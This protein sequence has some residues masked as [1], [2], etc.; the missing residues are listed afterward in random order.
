[1]ALGRYARPS[2]KLCARRRCRIY[3]D[4]LASDPGGGLLE[5]EAHAPY[6]TPA[7][8]QTMQAEEQ[9]T[10]LD[11]AGGDDPAQ[12][13]SVLCRHAAALAGACATP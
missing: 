5:I 11:Y 4:A 1:M 6:R 10:L 13:R 7:P 3:L 2:A 8:G 12:Q 9:W